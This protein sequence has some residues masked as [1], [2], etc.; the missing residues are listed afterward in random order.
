M[1]LD[2]L[3]KDSN[4]VLVLFVHTLNDWEY[5]K[6]H[7]AGDEKDERG[8]D[9]TDTFAARPQTETIHK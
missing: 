3:K 8:C 9:G 7:M 5:K 6:I 4:Y 1:Q 2:Q